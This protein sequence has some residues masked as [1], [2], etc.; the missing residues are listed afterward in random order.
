MAAHLHDGISYEMVLS[1]ATKK[2]AAGA[3]GFSILILRR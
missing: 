3:A 1:F 2:P